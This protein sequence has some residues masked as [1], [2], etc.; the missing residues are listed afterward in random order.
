MEYYSALENKIMPLP[1]IW[2][3]LEIIVPNEVRERQIYGITY[4]WNLKCYTDEL[5]SET[6]IDS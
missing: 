2:I 3:Q 1:A 4:M 6:E 5:I